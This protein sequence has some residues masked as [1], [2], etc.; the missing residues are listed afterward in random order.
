MSENQL[1]LLTRVIL[2]IHYFKILALNGYKN[3]KYYKNFQAG[4]T[5]FLKMLQNTF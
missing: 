2:R 3:T 5:F 1:I 4:F